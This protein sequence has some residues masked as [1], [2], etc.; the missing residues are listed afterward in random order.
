M[1]CVAPALRVQ[2]LRRHGAWPPVPMACPRCRCCPS[3]QCTATLQLAPR[4]ALSM[5]LQPRCRMPPTS[6]A[7]RRQLPQ[8][9][10]PHSSTVALPPARSGRA[11]HSRRSVGPPWPDL[12]QRRPCSRASCTYKRP[13]TTPSSPSQMTLATPR[14]GETHAW[15]LAQIHCYVFMVSTVTPRQV[16]RAAHR[17][18]SLAGR[19]QAQWASRMPAKP[20][21][22]QLRRQ[23]RSWQWT[24]VEWVLGRCMQCLY[25]WAACQF[26]SPPI[27]SGCLRSGALQVIVSHTAGETA[28]ERPRPGEAV[29]HQDTARCRIGDHQHSGVHPAA[30]QRLPAQKEAADLSMSLGFVHSMWCS[31][32]AA[33]TS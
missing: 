22:M 29:V 30:T 11:A 2:L 16:A 5:R 10:R 28:S 9:H 15:R 14:P 25:L 18:V 17:S 19:Q 12:Q 26:S 23:R 20:Q 7:G 13:A 6:C 33:T 21:A 8:L 31:M 4:A 3:A 24:R 1:C 32:S 27:Y